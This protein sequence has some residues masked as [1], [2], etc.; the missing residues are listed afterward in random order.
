[1]SSRDKPDLNME[2]LIRFAKAEMGLNGRWSPRLPYP[3]GCLGGLLFDFISGITGRP[4]PISSIRIKKFCANT[5][6]DASKAFAS[7]FRPPYTIYEGLRRT[8]RYEFCR[9]GRVR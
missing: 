6:F 8:I 1:M 2:S 3:V 4:L 9:V 5:C 7:G